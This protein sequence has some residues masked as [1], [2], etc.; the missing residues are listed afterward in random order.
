VSRPVKSTAVRAYL[1]TLD[2]QLAEA[3]ERYEYSL[4]E[5]RIV[6]RYGWWVWS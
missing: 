5:G 2:E 6:R 4:E 3:E 1:R